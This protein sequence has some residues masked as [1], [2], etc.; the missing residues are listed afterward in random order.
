MK[1]LLPCLALVLAGSAL[2]QNLVP[3]WEAALQPIETGAALGRSL[4]LEGDTLVAAD[5]RGRA[6][7]YAAAAGTWQIRQALVG[8]P[9][10]LMGQALAIDGDVLAVG[11]T[12]GPGADWSGG[13][14]YLFERDA[15][16]YWQ[17]LQVLHAPS[18][19]LDDGFGAALRLD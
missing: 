11:S 7:V 13:A 12:A 19:V 10:R 1:S 15:T 14:V 9:D 3:T 17:P 2:A 4:A 5:G 8:P 18:E 16:G 6:A